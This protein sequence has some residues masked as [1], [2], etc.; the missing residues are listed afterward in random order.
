MRFISHRLL[1]I[2][3]CSLLHT[4]FHV[5]PVFKNSFS[6]DLLHSLPKEQSEVDQSVA[7]WIFLLA[8]LEDQI[9]LD[10]AL[11][12]RQWNGA[13]NVLNLYVS[14][15]L[16]A[17]A[18]TFSIFIFLCVVFLTQDSVFLHSILLLFDFCTL[19]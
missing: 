8:F 6:K 4:T 12:C 3:Q 9:Q 19:G 14:P 11:G 18:S 16:S 1:L 17:P 5:F 13:C 2:T 10:L 7:P 15:K